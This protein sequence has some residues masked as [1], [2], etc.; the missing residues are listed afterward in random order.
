L[1]ALPDQA[2]RPEE[3]DGMHSMTQENTLV[4]GGVDSHADTHHAAALN[5]RGELL[6]TESFPTTTSGYRQLL[7][8]LGDFGEIDAI[9]VE[10]TG[11]YAAALVRYLREHGIAVIEVNQ[12]HA[13]TRRRVGKSDPID[14]E[15]A[16]RSFLAGKAKSVPKQ[17]NGIVE[18]IRLLRVARDSAVKSRSAALVQVRDLIITAPQ[19]LRDQLSDRKTL[20]GKATV[21]ARFRPSASELGCPSQ[22]AKFALRS[23][24]QRI[25][26]LDREIDA[27]DR[28]LKQLVATAAPRTIQLLGIS[29]GHAGQL[30]VTAGQNIDRLRGESSFAM[31]CGASP[32]PASSGKTVRHRL[33][34]GGDRQ[35]N[36]ALH[37]IVVVRLRYCQ[38]TRAYVQRR[39]REGMS[40]REIM[41]CL[42]RYI[43]REVYNS[44]RADLA[45]THPQP[46]PRTATTIMCGNPG[47]GIN[48]T[49]T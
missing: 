1:S 16:A 47:F 20:R 23:I 35:A 15:M 28:E 7:N 6:G 24:A 42:K 21:C 22:A 45:D 11:S 8:W 43:A 19:E 29:T 40:Q 48:R 13:H 27:L 10:S 26:A 4:V 30:L 44:L 39:A 32:L 33:N 9:A 38:R 34:P 49:R 41:R 18:S 37:L 25:E 5:E 3:E 14:A 12:P 31:L 2:A 46:R 17:T 36:R